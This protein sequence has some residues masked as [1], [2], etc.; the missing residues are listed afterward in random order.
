[1]EE[2]RTEE[3]WHSSL[4]NY[5]K[6]MRDVADTHSSLHE[7]A[8]YHFKK[9]NNW[10]GLPSVLIPL[11]MAPVSLM[12]ESV[13]TPAIQY[14]NAGGFM[15]TGVFTGVYSFFKYGEKMER[16]FAFS[17]RYADILT[18]I[19]SELIKERRHRIPADVMIV[20]VKMSVD[21]LKKTA[22]VIPQGLLNEKRRLMPND[23]YEPIEIKFSKSDSEP[24][25]KITP[26][27][28]KGKLK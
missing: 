28:T 12:L 6:H 25:C 19:E 9:R 4:E 14:V 13:G 16:H 10:F 24:D 23:E 11:I 21:N 3:P 26:E 17:A 5:L 20:K 18:D 1:M 8:G 15:L 7:Q 22:P 27:S 2:K